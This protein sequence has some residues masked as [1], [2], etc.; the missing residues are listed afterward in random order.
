MIV[1]LHLDIAWNALAGHSPHELGERRAVSLPAL[2]DGGVGVIG[3]TLFAQPKVGDGVGYVDRDG[4]A[5][6]CL[7]QM[8][9][10]DDLE[11]GGHLSLVRTAADLDR[12]GLR[13]AVLMEGADA[14]ALPGEDQRLTPQAWFDRGV[15]TVGLAW[16]ATRW[17][18]GTATPGPL[19]AEGA[20]LVRELDRVGMIHDVSHL[21]EAATDELLDVATGPVFASH[22]NC[23]EIVRE[24]P[25]GRHLPDRQIAWIARRGGIVGIN[26]FDWFLI[27]PAEL[28]ARRATLADWARHVRHACDV[29]GDADHV[30]LGSDADGGFGS[31]RLPRE[32]STAADWPR[33]GEALADAGFGDDEVRA[34]LEDNAMR[35]LRDSLPTS[36]VLDAS[37]DEGA[38][39]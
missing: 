10:Y 19:T 7:E 9:A 14:M 36:D 34:V 23:R 18:G 22:S 25:S 35:F 20:S 28:A 26:L 31:D 38:N 3:G 4:A 39:I 2:R 8:A 1:D 21:A 17:G 29:I 30:A 13:L 5:A 11:R 12:E 6:D 15:R 33:L 27:P 37:P 16:R 32:L 24:D